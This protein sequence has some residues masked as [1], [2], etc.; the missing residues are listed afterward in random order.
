MAK[1][2]FRSLAREHPEPSAFLAHANDVVVGEIAVGKF[3]T[4]AYVTVDAAGEVLCASAGHPEPR[5]LLPD[6]RVDGLPC[7]G[8]ALGIDAPQEYE[9]VRAELPPGA[10]V[11]L[12]TDGV[13]E[14]RRGSELFGTARLDTVLAAHAGEPAQQVADGVLAACRAFAGGDLPDDCA[15]VVIR[16]TA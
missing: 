16:R 4:M 11:V 5:L 14:S 1:F 3:I 12:Y 9:Q 6:G 13:I 8:L 15:I 10:S 2:T 7:G